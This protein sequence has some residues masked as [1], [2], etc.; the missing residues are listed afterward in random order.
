MQQLVFSAQSV[1]PLATWRLLMLWCLSPRGGNPVSFSVCKLPL[2]VQSLLVVV[3][4]VDNL[5]YQFSFFCFFWLMFLLWGKPLTCDVFNVLAC[6][7]APSLILQFFNSSEKHNL[8]PNQRIVLLCRVLAWSTMMSWMCR[9][10]PEHS[11]FYEWSSASAHR[12]SPCLL[13]TTVNM[14]HLT[15]L[16]SLFSY[17]YRM[18]FKIQVLSNLWTYQ[19]LSH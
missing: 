3:V 2:C 16:L 7:A 8:Q 15:C 13:L 14:L 17:V 19:S 5:D 9:K 12:T 6:C 10:D 18:V 1:T 11:Q 4:D